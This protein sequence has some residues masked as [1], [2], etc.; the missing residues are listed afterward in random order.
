MQYHSLTVGKTVIEFHNNWLGVETVI[1]NGQIVSKKSSV[2]GIDHYFTVMEEGHTNRYVLTT[3]VNS[4]MQVL[5][6]IRKN[7]TIIHPNILVQFG[8]KPKTAVNKFKKKGLEALQKYDLEEA[9]NLFEK[10]LD[11][12]KKDAETY[13]HMACAYSILEDT[14]K[15]FECIEKS[16]EYGLPNHEMILNHD[17]L[18]FLRMTEKFKEFLERILKKG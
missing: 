15:G 16:L 10:S 4:N 5:I 2:W 18:A 9:L 11:F 12:D 1:V 6:D 17:M 3:K 7:G 13:F 14:E 8:S